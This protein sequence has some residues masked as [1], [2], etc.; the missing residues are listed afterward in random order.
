MIQVKKEPKE[1]YE[2]FGVYEN[3]KFCGG[4]TNT[5]HEETNTPICTDCAKT[6]S[7]S[8]LIKDK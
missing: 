3:C 4:N 7:E 8:D 2:T 1:V 6:H 5:W